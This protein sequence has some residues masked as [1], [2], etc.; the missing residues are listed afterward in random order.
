[1]LKREPRIV[2]E[3]KRIVDTHFSDICVIDFSKQEN[4]CGFS[5][6]RK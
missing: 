5:K 2:P 6:R 1:M 3:H 4:G